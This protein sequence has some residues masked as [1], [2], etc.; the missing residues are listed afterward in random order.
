MRYGMQFCTIGLLSCPECG[1]AWYV[2]SHVVNWSIKLRCMAD[3]HQTLTGHDS[4]AELVELSSGW[5]YLPWSGGE[6]HE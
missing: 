4:G 3:D 5:M 6:D 2:P 1:V